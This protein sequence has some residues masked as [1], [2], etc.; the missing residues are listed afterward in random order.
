MA[1][2][3]AEGEVNNRMQISNARPR[4]FYARVAKKYFAGSDKQ[5]AVEELEITALGNAISSAVS[6]CDS[7]VKGESANLKKVQTSL[8]ESTDE[9]TNRPRSSPKITIWLTKHPNFKP[10]EDDEG[11]D[12]DDVPE[13]NDDAPDEAGDGEGADGD[14]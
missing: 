3:T 1:T 5:A 8:F 13:E 12:E 14:A 11:K 6:V 7:L 2:S 4:V 10:D 9:K